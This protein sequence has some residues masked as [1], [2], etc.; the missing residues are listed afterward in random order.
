MNIFNILL[1][2]AFFSDELKIAR[3]TPIY[4]TGDKNDFANYRPISVL[5]CFSKML[6]RIIYKRR[7]NHLLKNHILNPK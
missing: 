6:D 7:Y 3:V 4:K 5:P 2:K 1:E